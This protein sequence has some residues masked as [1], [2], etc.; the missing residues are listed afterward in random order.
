MA[1]YGQAHARVDYVR[2]LAAKVF[3]AQTGEIVTMEQLLRE[4]G[5]SPLPSP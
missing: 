5:G 4:R 2:V 3:T 1:Q